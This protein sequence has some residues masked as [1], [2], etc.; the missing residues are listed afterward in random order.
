MYFI[1][2]VGKWYIACKM[3][4]KDIKITIYY[5]VLNNL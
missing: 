3:Y 1:L 2:I 4:F 5:I